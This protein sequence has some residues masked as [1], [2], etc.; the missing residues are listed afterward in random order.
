[1]TRI[2]NLSKTSKVKSIYDLDSN[3]G[4]LVTVKDLWE[5]DLLEIVQVYGMEPPRNN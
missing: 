5:S 4:R 1:M 2:P 3:G